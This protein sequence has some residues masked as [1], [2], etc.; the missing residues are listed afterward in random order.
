[1]QSFS[2]ISI[3]IDLFIYKWVY[4]LKK[5]KSMYIYIYIIY[6]Y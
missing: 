4:L 1:M 2:K 3:Y 6:I 5:M